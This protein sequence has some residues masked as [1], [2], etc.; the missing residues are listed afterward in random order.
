MLTET[1]HPATVDSDR[2]ARAGFAAPCRFDSFRD[3]CIDA[4]GNAVE[5]P[6]TVRCALCSASL[7]YVVTFTD[8]AGEILAIG[9]ECAKWLRLSPAEKKA[10]LAASRE[11][12]A[13]AAAERAE[14]GYIARKIA[15]RRARDAAY[16]AKAAELL[17]KFEAERA[18]ARA[19]LERGDNPAMDQKARDLDMF[20]DHRAMIDRLRAKVAELDVFIDNARGRAA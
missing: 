11:A 16:R 19:K 3:V 6:E 7:R 9:K 10:A 13:L 12:R 4:D 2:L 1:T 15:E 14:P 8:A 17:A 18:A 5:C 20:G